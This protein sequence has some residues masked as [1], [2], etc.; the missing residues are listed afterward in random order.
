M[1]ESIGDENIWFQGS[2]VEICIYESVPE[3]QNQ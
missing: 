3:K 2:E 1:E